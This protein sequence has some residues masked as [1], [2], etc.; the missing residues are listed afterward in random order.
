MNRLCPSCGTQLRGKYRHY[1][2][3]AKCCKQDIRA[4][5]RAEILV[6][7]LLQ[8]KA[9]VLPGLENL[10]HNKT[11]PRTKSKI[12]STRADFRLVR[13]HYDIVIEV[14]ENQ[15][16]SRKP[17]QEMER[18]LKLVQ[19]ANGRPH[20]IFRLNPHT[21]S[22]THT[23]DNISLK[24]SPGIT[25]LE[26]V[27][28]LSQRVDFMLERIQMRERNVA[29]RE[30]T[31]KNYTM[32]ILYIEYLFFDQEIT[33]PKYERFSVRHYQTETDVEKRIQILQKSDPKTWT[34]P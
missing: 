15:H 5:G 1:G 24:R 20:I 27:N 6:K 17:T 30:R 11:D 28:T 3:C 31:H 34:K 10:I 7:S 16:S 29:R 13:N 18:M 25:G 12:T 33:N 23:G 32:P 21:Y 9:N 8:T 19:A 26:F 14:D 4:Q 22:C 2:L